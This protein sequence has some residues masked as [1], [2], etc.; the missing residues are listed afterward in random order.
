MNSFQYQENEALL[1]RPPLSLFLIKF[2]LISLQEQLNER[3]S[4]NMDELSTLALKLSTFISLNFWKLVDFVNMNVTLCQGSR[5]WFIM[6]WYALWLIFIGWGPAH[7]IH[8][9][10]LLTFPWKCCWALTTDQMT[11]WAQFSQPT[12]DR[13][14]NQIRYKM[15]LQEICESTDCLPQTH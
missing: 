13:S 4:E 8:P 1:L 9:D 14:N 11:Y 15:L 7:C 5:I 3:R 12:V 10:T 2:F 6:N